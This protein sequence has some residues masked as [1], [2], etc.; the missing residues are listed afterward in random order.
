MKTAK[1]KMLDMCF[2]NNDLEV[3]MSLG[4]FSKISAGLREMMCKICD[5]AHDRCVKLL[6]ARAK[7]R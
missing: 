1:K 4:E 3:M 5:Q 2:R 6:N 7:V